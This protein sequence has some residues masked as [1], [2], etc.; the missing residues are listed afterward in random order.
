[1]SEELIAEQGV[2]FLPM[3]KDKFDSAVRASLGQVK[4]DGAPRLARARYV[5]RWLDEGSFEGMAELDIDCD[6]STPD[7]LVLA[8]CG[9]A[10]GQ[11]RWRGR[12][13]VAPLSAVGEDGQFLVMVDQNGTLEIPWSLRAQRTGTGEYEFHFQLPACPFTRLD[14][15]LPSGW[16]PTTER[17]VVQSV[18]SESPAASRQWQV[19]VGGQQQFVLRLIRDSED[20]SPAPLH[21]R[22]S[23]TYRLTTSAL[24]LSASYRLDARGQVTRYLDVELPRELQ[25]TF[26]ELNGTRLS[27][28]VLARSAS[29]TVSRLQ[30]PYPMPVDGQELRL[31][32]VAPVIVDRMW[33]LPAPQL[34]GAQWLSGK[35]SLDIVEPLL[36]KAV[37][38]EGSQAT[39]VDSTPRPR[40]G[41]IRQFECYAANRS[42]KVQLAVA[43]PELVIDTGWL[44]KLNESIITGQLQ[45][46]I[47]AARGEPFE[48]RATVA[49]GWIVDGVQMDPPEQLEAFD[50]QGT[51]ATE[52]RVRF[53][54]PIR[55]RRTRVIVRA[56]RRGLSAG[57]TVSMEN[58]RFVRCSG[59][60]L[61]S[62]MFAIAVE[63]PLR[64]AIQGDQD[65]AHLDPQS[66]T[67]AERSRLN[68]PIG[69]ALFR[70][71]AAIDGMAIAVSPEQPTYSA[72]IHLDARVE[73]QSLTQAYEFQLTPERSYV[74]RFVVRFSERS[75]VEPSWEL[76]GI[77]DNSL[78]VRQLEAMDLNPK[79]EVWEVVALRPLNVPFKVRALRK[80]RFAGTERLALASIAESS[81]QTGSLQISVH[82]GGPLQIQT[83]NM[84]AV[85]LHRLSESEAPFVRG[86]FRYLPSQESSATVQRAESSASLPAAWIWLGRLNSRIAGAGEQEHEV[87]WYVEN[88]GL[89]TFT[90]TLPSGADVLRVLVD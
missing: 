6:K 20:A 61:R 38:P 88:T 70:D 56:H 36:A 85:A 46:D 80:T 45:A 48:L 84:T 44:V 14:L 52:L 19:E 41:E 16:E 53:K 15:E 64:L 27:R 49:P 32:L 25:L 78:S 39:G 11:P 1:M 3:R 74:A 18:P 62:G 4:Q 21:A 87:T 72:S 90:C 57:R 23:L 42:W 13:S 58:L 89:S 12:E 55:D 77:P 28:A 33:D 51:G 83:E 73:G 50:T 34:L 69:A 2:G 26:A 79:E 37:E 86:R 75:G 65:V 59:A 40:R 66:L 76:V 82:D 29:A 35:A 71:D 68:P 5:A 8:P 43:P 54:Q 67:E 7:Q 22:E 81:S 47:V 10:L 31:S 24:E 60:T 9:L 17:G 63:P 30:F